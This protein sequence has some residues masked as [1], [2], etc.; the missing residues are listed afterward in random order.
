[1]WQTPS[2]K[3]SSTLL[4]HVLGDYEF[5]GIISASSGRPI[6]VLQGSEISST[7]IG[8]DRATYCSG[9][10][11]AGDTCVPGASPYSSTT[12]GTATQCVSWLNPAA[13]EPL[14]VN[15]VNNL[16]V[17]GTAGNL[18]KNPFRLPGASNWDIQ[19]SKYFTITE[20]IK[21]QLRGEYFNVLNH[22]NFAPESTSSGTVNGNDHISSFDTLSGGNFGT[23]R[24]GQA[25]DP[26]IAQLA[27][28]II[29]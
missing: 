17:F 3:G 14:K 1:V 15:G 10:G 23:F 11:A 5:S 9:Q 18:R 29:F 8:L 20:R 12:C 28:K 21:L 7:G 22:P 6:T 16:V 2:F 25:S 26:R 27:A 19:L 24:S 4:R 13:F